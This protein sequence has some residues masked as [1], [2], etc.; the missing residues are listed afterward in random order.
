MRIPFNLGILTR[1]KE[2]PN[3]AKGFVLFWEPKWVQLGCKMLDQKIN[4]LIDF[5]FDDEATYFCE[6]PVST[7]SWEHV[8]RM[9]RG[10]SSWLRMCRVALEHVGIVTLKLPEVKEGNFDLVSSQSLVK[11]KVMMIS[12]WKAVAVC[13]QDVEVTWCMLPQTAWR[14][15]YCR[16]A[17]I[18]N[19]P[20]WEKKFCWVT[21]ISKHFFSDLVVTDH[22]SK[23]SRGCCWCC[24]S[25]SGEG[26]WVGEK[27][28]GE[29]S[30]RRRAVCKQAS[31][32]SV[33]GH[34]PLLVTSHELKC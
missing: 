7:C 4:N 16:W 6:V 5:F 10:C 27:G 26:L 25:M 17:T 21:T 1:G 33:C 31:W 12:R 23:S 20:N 15:L 28:I 24:R 3:I 8:G 30:F 9:W 14:W 18:A 11:V 2:R 34:K 22:S 29:P 32:A 19:S 13:Q